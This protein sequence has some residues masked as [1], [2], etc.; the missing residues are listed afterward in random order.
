MKEKYLS[1]F[2]R[3]AT[4]Q[5]IVIMNGVVDEY[6]QAGFR[7]TV[8]QLYYQLVARGHIP[9]T[10][11]SY[12]RITRTV[13]D[14]RLA[15]LM[16]WNAIEDRTRGFQERSHWKN[17]KEVLLAVSEQYHMDMWEHQTARLL[18][19]VEKEALAGVLSGVCHA[20]DIPLLSA[21]GYPS[22][23][24][25]KDLADR[26]VREAHS[27]SLPAKKKA[28][29]VL[30]DR[31]WH[32][33]HLGDHD[34]S[35][36]D[37]TR[38]LVDRLDLLSYSRTFH[39]HRIAL[40]RDQIDEFNP[41]PNPAKETDARYDRYRAEHGEESFEL[42]ALDPTYL[43]KLV[44]DRAMEFVDTRVWRARS[45]EIAAVKKRLTVVAEDFAV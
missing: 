35:G 41:P 15:G 39:L 40:N 30:R 1:M 6:L 23:S 3:N 28:K 42:D 7:L 18:C 24:V 21:R 43:A 25:L 37:M 44:E 14:A 33:L 26:I 20:M 11:K 8:R 38:D 13:N 45:K 16:D 4:K 36:I 17:G 31:E 19:V 27:W 34:P 5:L 9:N 12:K 10:E 29:P 32:I 22:V 2:F